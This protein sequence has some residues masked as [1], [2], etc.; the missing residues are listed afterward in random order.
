MRFNFKYLFFL[1]PLLLFIGCEHTFKNETI[2]FGGQIKNPK[3]I[4]VSIF[5]G[6][7]KVAETNLNQDHKFLFKLDSLQAGLYT[8]KHGEEF[9]YIYLEPKDSLLIRLNTWDFDESLVFS[10]KGAERNNFLIQLFL[11]NE[12]QGKLFSKYFSLDEINFIKKIDSIKNSKSIQYKQFKAGTSKQSKKFNAL[13]NMTLY[14]PLYTNKEKYA[15]Y[16]KHLNKLD[17]LPNLSQD[18][19]NFRKKVDIN[20]NLFT[21]YYAFKSYR[22]S[23]L[24]NITSYKNELDNSSYHISTLLLQQ[25]TKEIT[26]SKLRNQMIQETYFGILLDESLSKNDKE[27]A[28]RIFSKNCTD[29][30]DNEG[31]NK[32]IAVIN[33][34]KKGSSL[35]KINIKSTSNT[36]YTITNII[37]SNTVIYSWPKG[38]NRIQNMAKRVH[39]LTNKYPNIRFI[40]IDSHLG[41]YNWKAYIKSNNLDSNNQFQ[42]VDKTTDNLF[43]Y[44]I[45]RAIITN[46]NG[47]IMSDFTFLSHINFE[48]NLL[49]LEKNKLN[50]AL[51]NK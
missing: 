20:S 34:Q 37:N 6:N 10:G 26:N 25:I 18:F 19:Y 51:A 29:K 46:N 32:L 24:H 49:F 50:T 44:D 48:R 15:L 27:M 11:D 2:F 13:V 31:I 4:E 39:Y 5:K 7:E 38:L 33:S 40:G 9:Q 22:W 12:Q 17:K 14:F 21:N 8:F 42:L 43:S 3:G 23:H 16:N 47:I 45:P 41:N 36:V 35:P 1:T 28:H 30:K